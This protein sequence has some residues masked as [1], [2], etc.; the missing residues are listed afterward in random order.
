MNGGSGWV[1]VWLVATTKSR[2]WGGDW[3]EP[4]DNEMSGVLEWCLGEGT[5]KTSFAEKLFFF[6]LLFSAGGEN[7]FHRLN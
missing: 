4:A 2:E 3:R 7:T 5:E 6:F 1:C